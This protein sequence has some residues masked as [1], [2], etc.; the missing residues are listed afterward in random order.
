MSGIF[1]RNLNALSGLLHNIRDHYNDSREHKED[2]GLKR[3]NLWTISFEKKA[4]V[5]VDVLQDLHSN[6]SDKKEKKDGM[7]SPE[8]KPKEKKEEEESNHVPLPKPSHKHLKKFKAVQTAMEE[9]IPLLE[10]ES[11]CISPEDPNKYE[12]QRRTRR[13]SSVT[14][15]RKDSIT[16]LNLP[17]SAE[18][19]VNI[20]TLFPKQI[21][22]VRSILLEL[23]RLLLA[24]VVHMSQP[25]STFWKS[26]DPPNIRS[27]EGNYFKTLQSVMKR[28]ELDC[29]YLAN[30]LFQEEDFQ[31]AKKHRAL[32]YET[33]YLCEQKMGGMISFYQHAPL[34]VFCLKT[35]ALNYF[36]LPREVGSVLYQSFPIKTTDH[37]TIQ[38][39]KEEYEFDI[40]EEIPNYFPEDSAFSREIGRSRC[41]T[42]KFLQEEIHNTLKFS[43]QSDTGTLRGSSSFSSLEPMSNEASEEHPEISSMNHTLSIFHW[44]KFHEDVLGQ[45]KKKNSKD[46]MEKEMIPNFKLDINQPAWAINISKENSL[47]FIFFKEWIIH[48][49]SHLIRSDLQ[50]DFDW[51]SVAGYSHLMRHFLILVKS[52]D[53]WFTGH[54]NECAMA[55]IT[56]DSQLLNLYI[57]ILFLKTPAN[58]PLSIMGSLSSLENWFKFANTNHVRFKSPTFDIKFFTKVLQAIAEA[59]HHQSVGRTLSLLY[60]HSELFERECR[61]DLYG[62]FLLDQMFDFYFCHWDEN[63]RN[64]FHQILVFKILRTKRSLLNAPSSPA[65]PRVSPLLRQSMPPV[66]T[67]DNLPSKTAPFSPQKL[68]PVASPVPYR[69]VSRSS[70]AKSASVLRAE[71]LI[72]IMLLNKIE[73]NISRIESE[74]ANL[75]SAYDNKFMDTRKIYA[76]KSLAEYKIYMGR[77]ASWE[78]SGADYPKMVPLSLVRA[79]TRTAPKEE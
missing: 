75:E 2:E 60:Y 37:P 23:W 62:G 33:Q 48:L 32:M 25:N 46:A 13:H 44:N 76:I 34:F 15:L 73:E 16:D 71:E 9:I 12:R 41:I 53:D 58:K 8:S 68:S 20:G 7:S 59:D 4:K 1:R 69:R 50:E 19:F 21:A 30:N 63:V 77:Y 27:M 10:V 36:R 18:H 28:G 65:E 57:K 35:F 6:S 55:T 31:L 70:I 61:K 78:T 64:S 67:T 72:D 54:I 45:N 40:I 26:L 74:V 39:I 29:W 47:Y 56:T 14:T 79:G 17:I 52:S 38:K 11:F 51:L 49:R 24:A 42:D 5:F 3:Y 43:T 66:K 22:S